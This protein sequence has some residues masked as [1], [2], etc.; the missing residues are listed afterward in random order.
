MDFR[1][2]RPGSSRAIPVR[3]RI[4]HRDVRAIARVG[5]FAIAESVAGFNR[6]DGA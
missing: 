1:I 4:S 6:F 2:D 5:T 3:D